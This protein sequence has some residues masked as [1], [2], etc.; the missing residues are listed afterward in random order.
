MKW[1]KTSHKP[2]SVEEINKT[3]FLLGYYEGE[4]KIFNVLPFLGSSSIVWRRVGLN[5]YQQKFTL[6]TTPPDLWAAVDFPI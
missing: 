3:P 6:N 4:Q 5:I 2:P 1:I